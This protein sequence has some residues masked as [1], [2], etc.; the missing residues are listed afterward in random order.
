MTASPQQALTRLQ[1]KLP[2]F[3]RLCILKARRLGRKRLWQLSTGLGGT[4]GNEVLYRAR[5]PL[6]FVCRRVQLLGM[7][8]GAC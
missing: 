3:R 8:L 5:A 1:L 2:E 6:R 7:Q 4:R